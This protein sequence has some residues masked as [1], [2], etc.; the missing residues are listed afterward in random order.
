MLNVASFDEMVA[1]KFFSVS[2]FFFQGARM[3]AASSLT[4]Y[5][6]DREIGNKKGKAI[7][8]SLGHFFRKHL[9]SLSVFERV[10]KIFLG[11]VLSL[12]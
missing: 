7:K 11:K 8:L 5:I 12:L 4:L 6:Y 10:C 1:S 9:V 3:R 2:V